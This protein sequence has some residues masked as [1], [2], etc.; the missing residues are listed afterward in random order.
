MSRILIVGRTGQ[1]ARALAHELRLNSQAF[2][3]IGS[4]DIDLIVNPE[5]SLPFIEDPSITA[6]INAS[7]FTDVDGAQ[8]QP[9]AATQLNGVAP[10]YMAQAC[11]AKSIPFIHVST[12]YVFDGTAHKPYKPDAPLNPIN[13][14]GRS[15][16]KGERAVKAA[17]GSAVILRTSWVYDGL[18]RNFLTTMMHIGTREHSVSVVDDQIGR[19]TYAGHLA[20]AC[21]V[22]LRHMPDQPKVHHVTNSGDPISWAD[23]ATEIFKKENIKCQTLRIETSEYPT[24]AKRPAYSVLDISSFE[25]ATGYKLPHWH[26]GLDAALAERP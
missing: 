16:A 8:S 26:D 21:H 2:K 6:V 24:P 11:K 15:K 17:G 25:A 9:N 18:D 3:S 20:K 4:S 23:F 13:A 22:M 10:G 1:L 5:G 12:D 14:Y 19:P 7:G